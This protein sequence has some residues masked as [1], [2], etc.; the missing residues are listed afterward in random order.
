[1]LGPEVFRKGVN[2]YLQAHANGNATSADFWQAMAKV[3]GKPVDKIMPTFVMQSGVPLVTVSG[4]CQAARKP[5]K[6]AQERFLLSS[7]AT[8]QCRTSS[9]RFRFAPKPRTILVRLAISWTDRPR[10][11][12]RTLAGLVYCQP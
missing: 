1:M 11:L 9:G 5:L 4:S 8:A 2:A 7:S 10:A 6:L 12:T 3:S